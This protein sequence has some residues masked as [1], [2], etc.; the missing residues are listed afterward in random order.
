MREDSESYL[1]DSVCT[2]GTTLAVNI[3]T[4]FG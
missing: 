4:V 1:R 2:E 3:E